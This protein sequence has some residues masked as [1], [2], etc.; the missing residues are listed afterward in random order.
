L[1][2]KYFD[3]PSCHDVFANCGYRNMYVKIL[4]LIILAYLFDPSC[5]TIKTRKLNYFDVRIRDT[6]YKNKQWI[7]GFTE[8]Q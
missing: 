8:Y 6:K 7:L 1:V 4:S 5:T 3:L 2:E